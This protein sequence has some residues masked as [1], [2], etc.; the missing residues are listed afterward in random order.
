MAGIVPPLPL[1]GHVHLVLF[2]SQ[3]FYLEIPVNIISNLCLKPLKYLR[4]LGWCVLGVEGTLED[5]H[6]DQVD[7]EGDIVDQHVYKYKLPLDQQGFSLPSIMKS[8]ADNYLEIL[9]HAVDLEVIKQRTN[10]PSETTRTREEF[11]TNLVERDGE[12]CVW[13]G[14]SSSVGM[15]IIP[16]KRGDEAC[17]PRVL[18]PL[19]DHLRS[20]FNSS[21]RTGRIVVEGLAISEA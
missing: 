11:R 7:L 14:Q 9:L 17:N 6:Q 10:V 2:E 5:A 8:G 1:A 15:H 3:H 18:V 16:F 21:S 19:T 4:Y 12:C 20:G 13:T